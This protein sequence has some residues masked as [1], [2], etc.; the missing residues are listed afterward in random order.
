MHLYCITSSLRGIEGASLLTLFLG[1]GSECYE[2]CGQHE[3]SLE[4]SPSSRCQLSSLKGEEQHMGAQRRWEGFELSLIQHQFS[5][6]EY[7]EQFLESL[8]VL[9]KMSFIERISR[10]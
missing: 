4:K 9:L 7:D 2:V 1:I 3:S 10:S 8:H 5:S 6:S